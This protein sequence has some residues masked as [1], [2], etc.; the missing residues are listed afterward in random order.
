VGWGEIEPA[1]PGAWRLGHRPSLD[2]LRG[3]AVLLVLL[4]HFGLIPESAATVG[5]TLF[6][7]LSGYLITG[8]LL[9]EHARSGRVD[10]LAFYIRRAR[11]LLPALALLLVALAGV[12]WL[13]GDLDRWAAGAIPVVFYVGNWGFLAGVVPRDLWHT[14][15]LAIEE[16]FY[17]LWPMTL[18]L[19][20]GRGLQAVRIGLVVLICLSLLVTLPSWPGMG[21]AYYGTAERA[22]ELLAGSLIAVLA[23][24]A[25]RDPTPSPLA[26]GL[27]ALCLVPFCVFGWTSALGPLLLVL[28]ASVLVAW[29]AAG[30]S[31]LARWPLTGTGRISYGLYLF[32]YPLIGLAAWP[33][34]IAA[35]YGLAAA[36]W[37]GVERH[38]VRRRSPAPLLVTAATPPTT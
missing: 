26:A 23:F 18:A 17:L 36:S 16:Q 21:L 31:R 13:R 37:W 14:W 10:L 12:A 7:V 24:S 1:Q 19:L 30:P 5:V 33:V 6:F 8:L 11:R 20:M 22:K 27:A 25:G 32:H 9:G 35:T 4:G 3:I 29:F 2:A 15:S 38:V 34:L 28:P